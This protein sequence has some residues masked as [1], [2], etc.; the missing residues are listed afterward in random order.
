MELYHKGEIQTKDGMEW[1]K[2]IMTT[3]GVW[4]QNGMDPFSLVV[5]PRETER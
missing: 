1:N 5:H 2:M 3:D 4:C